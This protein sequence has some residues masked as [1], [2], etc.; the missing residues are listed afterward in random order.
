MLLASQLVVAPIQILAYLTCMAVI[1]GAKSVE[2]VV[3]T[4]KAGFGK[5]LRITW[6]T[7]PVYTVFAQQY[8]PPEMWVPFFNFMQFLTG[9]YFNVKIKKM[10]LEAEAKA[11]KEKEKEESKKD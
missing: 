9:T 2:E 6:M 4:V 10:R 8:L 7:A 3:K 1:N 11:K 5:V